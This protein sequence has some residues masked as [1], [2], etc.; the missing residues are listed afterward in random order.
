MVS[1]PLFAVAPSDFPQSTSS[2]AQPKQNLFFE[3]MEDIDAFGYTMA[4]RHQRSPIGGFLTVFAILALLGGGL[5]NLQA[6]WL[7]IQGKAFHTSKSPGATH[8]EPLP[9][10]PFAVTLSVDGLPFND[11]R[12]FRWNIR[13]RA[14]YYS[15]SEPLNHPRLTLPCPI[16]E[17]TV[18]NPHNLVDEDG[19]EQVLG[20]KPGFCP[21]PNFSFSTGLGALTPP[22]SSLPLSVVGQYSAAEYYYVD[23]SLQRCNDETYASSLPSGTVCATP[24]EVASLFETSYLEFS[25]LWK[26]Q[27]AMEET[28]TWRDVAMLNV[29]PNGWLGVEVFFVETKA[30]RNGWLDDYFGVKKRWLEFNRT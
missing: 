11:Q 1:K 7:A 12:Y 17:C 6:M 14:I 5:L 28:L 10:V 22:S 21:D 23:V 18:G 30:K 29:D 20:M 16:E 27:D 15:D 24:E 13:Q 4:V 9:L 19:N 25:I 3:K 2:V 26:G 8:N